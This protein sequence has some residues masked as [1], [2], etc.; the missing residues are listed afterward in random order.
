MLDKKLQQ[1]I[2][3]K[4]KGKGGPP[5]TESSIIDSKDIDT[6]DI[7]AMASLAAKIADRCW[8]AIKEA[9]IT[10]TNDGVVF[11]I[12]RKYFRGLEYCFK[13]MKED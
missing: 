10:S 13:V 12:D 9:R 3:N 8:P 6:I 4:F 11:K 2:I 5:D 1:K 7:F